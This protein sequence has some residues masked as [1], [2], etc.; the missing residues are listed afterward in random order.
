LKWKARWMRDLGPEGVGGALI[1]ILVIM[2]AIFGPFLAPQSPLD[3][4]DAPL[5]P[6]SAADWLGTDVLGRDVLSRVLCG[7][8]RILGGGA[9]ATGGGVLIGALIGIYAGQKKGWIDNLLMRG[10]DAAL[11]FPQIILVLLFV[12]LLGPQ[13]WLILTLVG[14]N[15]IPAV[16]R[17][18]RGGAVRI[19][20]EDHIQFCEAVGMPRW[21]II[22]REIL[23]NLRGILVV[24]LGLRFAYSVAL[25]AGLGFL[26]LG[27]QPPAADWGLMINENRIAMASNP[28][29]VVAPVLMIAFLTI[30]LNLV[31]DA[32]TRA[33][34]RRGGE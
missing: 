9:I 21:Q 12:S 1:A 5:A 8:Y 32:A 31:T 17:V 28:W 29:P 13:T 14:F 6:P 27:T 34:R 16:A 3:F 11:A 30:G 4:V 7:G 33:T 15:H 19:V 24:E 2:L 25:I 10:A 23:P 18:A 26:G 22:V 20:E